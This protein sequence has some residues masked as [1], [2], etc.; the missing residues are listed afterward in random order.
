M[1]H[2]LCGV[3]DGTFVQSHSRLVRLEGWHVV[4]LQQQ[5]HVSASIH[6]LTIHAYHT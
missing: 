1:L 6:Q 2:Q 5:M 4:S 3:F